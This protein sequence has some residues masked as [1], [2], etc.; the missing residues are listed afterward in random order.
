MSDAESLNRS[1][2][3]SLEVDDF[4]DRHGEE[5]K[6]AL[7]RD[8]LLRLLQ[9]DIKDVHDQARRQQRALPFIYCPA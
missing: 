8:A 5:M 9:Q 4:L 6:R 1:S 7:D 3:S 2:I